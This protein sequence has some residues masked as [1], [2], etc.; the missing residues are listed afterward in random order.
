LPGPTQPKQEQIFFILVNKINKYSKLAISLLGF[1]QIARSTYFV[2][3]FFKVYFSRAVGQL[4][5]I[6]LAL[7]IFQK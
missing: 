6:C 3:A 7:P 4:F 5:F 1:A 2:P